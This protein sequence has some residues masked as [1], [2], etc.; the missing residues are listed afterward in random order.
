MSDLADLAKQ[1]KDLS[2]DV[3]SLSLSVKQL[4][5]RTSR[6]EKVTVAV[7]VGLALDIVLSIALAITL[8]NLSSLQDREAA[9]RQLA[10]CP[11]YS[12]ILGSF[13][14][15]SRPAGPEREKYEQAFVEMRHARDTLACTSSLVP[16]STSS[17]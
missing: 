1:A 9:T 4:G 15:E 7:V 2:G 11:L 16:P 14:P 17:R 3:S 10:L 8:A 13:R 5:E 6:S 12:L